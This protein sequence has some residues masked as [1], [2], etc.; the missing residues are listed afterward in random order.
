LGSELTQE[1]AKKHYN[2]CSKK[3][4]YPKDWKKSIAHLPTSAPVT[5]TMK[6]LKQESEKEVAN[7]R[8]KMRR[9][10]PKQSA[11]LGL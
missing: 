11:A 1:V 2:E 8:E 3:D 7:L 6:R 9:L 10:F 4:E 5:R